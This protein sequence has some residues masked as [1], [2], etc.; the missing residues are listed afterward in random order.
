MTRFVIIDGHSQIYRALYSPTASG[1]RNNQG[2]VIGGL[3][4]FFKIFDSILEVLKPD[5]LVVALDGPRIELRR[6]AL[7][8]EYKAT[9]TSLPKEISWQVGEIVKVLRCL[10]VSTIQVKSWEA[11]DVI[12]SLVDICADPEIEIVVV[13]R[14]KDLQQVLQPN[15]VIYEPTKADWV[16]QASAKADW[17]VPAHKIVEVQCL[18][19]DTADNVPGV[20]GIGKVKATKLVKRFETA[21][22]VWENRKELPLV[23]CRALDTFDIS[24]GYQLVRLRCDLK[25]CLNSE[26]LEWSGYSQ[27]ALRTVFRSFGI[28]RS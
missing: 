17:G 8:S 28:V 20:V 26:D 1:I 2:Q 21:Q 23:L 7:F 6:R 27:R 12:A 11:D 15:V 3:I 13:T 25:I 9:R 18:M 24:L 10:K 22:K 16:D 14:D 19:G 4:A 5:Y